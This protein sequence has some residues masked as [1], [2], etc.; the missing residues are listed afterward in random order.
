MDRINNQADNQIGSQA[1]NQTNFVEA[2]KKKLVWVFLSVLIGIMAG[3]AA[4]LFLASLKWV[5]DY[6]L[7]HQVIIWALPIAGLFVGWMY[8]R[9]G[10]RANGGNNLIL[11]E[12]HDPK[13]VLPLR[14]APFVLI[15]TLL[16]HLFG[17]SAGR[18]GTAVQMG[19]T[20][21]DQLSEYFKITAQDRKILL[22]AGAGAG[23]GAVIGAP[24]SG[25]IFGME[26]IAIGGFRFQTWLGCF[27]ECW[28]ASFVGFYT[29]ILLQ[30]PHTHYP[31][32]KIPALDI[33]TLIYVVFAGAL[34]GLSS[35]LF[36][37]VTH[38]VEK[39]NAKYIKKVPL[40][41]FFAGLVLIV[42]YRL[43]GSYQYA[44]L[45]LEYIQKGLVEKAQLHVPFYKIFFTAITVG[46]GFKGGEFIPLVYIGT[47]LGSA[48]GMIL[49]ISFQLLA[50]LGFAAVFGAA[51]NTPLACAVMAMEIFGYQI[52]IY[53]LVAC[54]VAYYFSGHHGIYKSQKVARKKHERFLGF[55]RLSS[56]K[57]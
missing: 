13:K 23:F 40:K 20:L 1:S 28:V 19:A 14:M 27:V 32:F 48:L 11:D 3:A 4:A 43:E 33:R 21:A 8:W 53:A 2:I 6:R 46:S 36:T 44:G 50:A 38:L 31:K 39:F 12:I 51:A 49:P 42:L 54:Y 35:K 29:V 41:P 15:G 25:A 17:G 56:R 16:T 22:M 34:F 7:S 47:T 30:A 10:K 52:G 18:E 55:F 5:T 26:V 24:W 9:Y 45:G 57:Q 37:I